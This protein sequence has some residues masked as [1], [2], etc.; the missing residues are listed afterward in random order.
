MADA[1]S[2]M[3][4]TQSDPVRLACLPLPSAVGDIQ[5]WGRQAVCMS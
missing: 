5:V 1:F 3:D 2:D 4:M